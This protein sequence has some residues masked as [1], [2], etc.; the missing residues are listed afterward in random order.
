MGPRPDG[1][2]AEVRRVL[3]RHEPALKRKDMSFEAFLARVAREMSAEAVSF[4]RM[5]AQGYEAAEPARLSARAVAEE[6]GEEGASRGGTGAPNLF[7][8]VTPGDARAHD[9]VAYNTS[10][11]LPECA[12]PP[13]HLRPAGGYGALLD[14]LARSLGSA[15][16]VRLR[17]VV[18]A[19]RWKRGEVE[20][21]GATSMADGGSRMAKGS[22]FRVT[23]KK[24]IVTLPLG[25]LQLAPRARGAVRFSPALA[26]KRRPLKRL[27]AG[28]VIKV[29]LLFRS[30]FWE[31]LDG[32]RYRDASFFHS[33]GTLFPTFWTAA[34]ERAPLLNAWAGG[35]N[36]LR[37]TGK[38]TREIV[39]EAV[40]CLE[41]MFGHDGIDGLLQAAWVH[42]WQTDPYARGAYSYVGVGGHGARKALAAP[43]ARTLYFAGEAT[44][45]EGEPATVAGA[46]QSGL[47]AAREVLRD[48]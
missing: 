19:V 38:N 18:R 17:G 21:A 36:A 11:D 1:I 13:G 26:S 39:H 44:D 15:V 43:L 41:T 5:R 2:E 34:P 7:G 9:T 37:L 33:P 12:Q 3:R 45:F 35:P 23:A 48:R 16:E 32:G 4:A 31:E 27:V 10:T 29:P 14:S 40:R 22:G 8:D 47:R 24:A 30:A 20:V 28:S 25:V 42:D 46:L 6:W